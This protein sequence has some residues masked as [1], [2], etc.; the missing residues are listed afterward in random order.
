MGLDL[1]KKS[2]NLVKKIVVSAYDDAGVLDEVYT[3]T[4]GNYVF[5]ADG[6]LLEWY[7]KGEEAGGTPFQSGRSIFKYFCK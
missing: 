3:T 2:R 1:G 6:Y 5:S 7:S 4:Y